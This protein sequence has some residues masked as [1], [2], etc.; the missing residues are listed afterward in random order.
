MP[1]IVIIVSHKLC[2]ESLSV[3]S[4]CSKGVWN[5]INKEQCPCIALCEPFV[6]SGASKDVYFVV[7]ADFPLRFV[8]IF[9]TVLLI[10]LIPDGTII[11]GVYFIFCNFVHGD[12]PR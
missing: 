12:A 9:V 7:I 4:N 1:C 8:R 6:V 3:L 11:I 2:D 10:K 5:I